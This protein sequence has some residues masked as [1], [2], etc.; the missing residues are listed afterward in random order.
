MHR[1]LE[2]GSRTTSS[3]S[4]EL[5]RSRDC[6]P[7]MSQIDL[8]VTRGGVWGREICSSGKRVGV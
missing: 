5:M 8:V 3:S 6:E 4:Q 1:K 7:E 2:A